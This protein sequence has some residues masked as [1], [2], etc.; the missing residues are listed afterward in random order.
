MIDY[1]GKKFNRWTILKF[2]KKIDG[3]YYWLCKCS[4]GTIKSRLAYGITS[5]QSK[6]CG[7]YKRDVSSTNRIKHNLS[8]TR[9]YH[10]WQGMKQRCFD[11]K[12]DAYKNYGGRGII[13]C[14][15]WLNFNNFVNDMYKPYQEHCEKYGEKNTSIDRI[16]NNKGYFLK[17]CRWATSKEQSNNTRKSPYNN[18]ITFNNKKISIYKFTQI[19]GINSIQYNL[20]KDKYT[21]EQIFNKEYKFIKQIAY[22]EILDTKQDT[23]QYLKDAQQKVLKL[24]YGLE[25]GIFRTLEDVSKLVGVTRERVRQIEEKSFKILLNIDYKK[26]KTKP[27]SIDFD[28]NV[29]YQIEELFR[30]KRARYYRYYKNKSKIVCKDK[31]PIDEIDN[32]IRKNYTN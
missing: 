17:N 7:C 20:L 11:K 2:D 13:I 3:E 28:K 18:Y 8:R 21:S 22:K 14:K 27:S 15:E 6:S 9:F 4:C 23:I 10:I 25:D 12:S 19:C 5:G 32:Y 30:A 16:D 24:R 29:D 1:T 26:E 31:L